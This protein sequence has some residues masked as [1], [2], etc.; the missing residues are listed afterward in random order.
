M[1]CPLDCVYLVEARKHEK[2]PEIDQSKVPNSDIQVTEDFLRSNDDLVG[3]M[4]AALLEGSMETSAIDEDVRECLE[5]TIRTHRTLGTGLV[6]ETRPASAYAAAIQQRIMIRV[7]EYRAYR[8]RQTGMTSVRDA[9]V[10]G[11]LVF[12]QRVAMHVDNGR[13]R[14]RSFVDF[15][16]ARFEGVGYQTDGSAD[17]GAESGEGGTLIL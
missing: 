6:Y 5:A 16:K 10:L 1:D 9:E 3:V 14:G 8:H 13:R 15:L 11:V 4:G 2:V 17:R 7:N 12:F